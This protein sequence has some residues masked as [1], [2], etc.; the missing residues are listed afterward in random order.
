MMNNR[1]LVVKGIGK[2]AATPDLIVLNINLEVT[3]PDYERT[4]Q[5]SAEMLDALRTA[6]TSAG[7]DGKELKTTSFSINTKYESY[8][9]KDTYK[10]R[11]VG[12][13]C[14]HGLRLEFDLDMSILATTLGLIARCEADPN[15]NIKFSVKDPN[16]VSEQL[17]E[18]AVAN[19]KWKATILAKSAGVALG[20]IQRIDYNW[21]DIHL[22]SETD[23]N[24]CEAAPLGG[25][26][27]KDIA[28]EPEEIN[29][30]DTATVVWAIE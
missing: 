27:F 13:V 16:A 6:I 2:A 8:K 24:V 23:Y 3:E 14:S 11:F 28:I 22:Y 17:L 15:F 30:S 9:E 29:V 19:A 7:H 20:A 4:M 5:R 10:Q 18:S 26:A 1:E 21:S 12:Y 25:S